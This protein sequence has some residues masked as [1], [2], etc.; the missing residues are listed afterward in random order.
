MMFCSL[1]SL[2]KLLSSFKFRRRAIV[3]ETQPGADPSTTRADV[4]RPLGDLD[5]A[6][7]GRNILTLTLRTLSSVSSNI[8]FG[9]ILSSAIDPLLDI[10]ERIEVRVILLLLKQT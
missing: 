1:F 7:T 9:S 10:T 4:Q 5:A 8:P 2:F 6:H 3:T